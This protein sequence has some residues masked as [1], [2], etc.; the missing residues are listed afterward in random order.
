[1]RR[2]ILLST[3]LILSA[4]FV[5]LP[6]QQEDGVGTFYRKAAKEYAQGNFETAAQ[7]F[8]DAFSLNRKDDAAALMSAASYARAGNKTLTV[9]WLKKLVQLGSC[10]RP[11][12]ESFIA[13]QREEEF[14]KVAIQL[15]RCTSCGPRST[16][17]FTI[18]LK[19]LIPENIAF[20]PLEKVFYV[21]S[22]YRKQ[23]IRIRNFDQKTPEFD[24]LPFPDQE[25]IH[26]VLGMK[27]DASRRVLLALTSTGPQM[28][29]YSPSL[30][31][32]T[33]L[34]KF[35]LKT[36]NLL[37]S[38]RPATDAP[39]GFNDL[40]L[41]AEG[42]AYITDSA[43]GEIWKY[44]REA[45][46][47]DRFLPGGHLGFPNGIAITPDGKKLFV[48][49]D[50]QQ[51][52]YRVDVTSRTVSRLPQRPGIS[53][54]GIDGLY[55]VGDSLIGVVPLISGGRLLRF[56]LEA[57]FES[58]RRSEIIECNH[59]SFQFP[60][61]G[62]LVENFLYYIA[63]SQLRSFHPDG[64]IFPMERLHETVILKLKL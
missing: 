22:L 57:D 27:V 47:L 13:L 26:S 51:G 63:N 39:H 20:D 31:G 46:S 3:I 42:D 25:Q 21:G 59:P 64:Q 54:Y 1:M 24:E 56:Q 55:L 40:V 23:I 44:S 28:K 17:A 12:G 9:L 19:D 4:Q 10:L 6:A 61:T 49:D 5:H 2:I 48:A 45:E 14:R 62:V 36:G 38:F 60:T 7:A 15:D 8:Q 35:D 18:P 30:A 32:R 33:A 43:S 34:L 16:M 11:H 41:N 29:G 52:I 37:H 58:I 50:L 53:P